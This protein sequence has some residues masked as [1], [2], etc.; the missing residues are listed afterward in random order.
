M[1]GQ[2]FKDN[3]ESIG[4]DI[5]AFSKKHRLSKAKIKQLEI[6]INDDIEPD[7]NIE[8]ELTG[9]LDSDIENY[10]NKETPPM[11]TEKVEDL[12]INYGDK[13]FRSKFLKE[14][15]FKDSATP[16]QMVNKTEKGKRILKDGK[17]EMVEIEAANSIELDYTLKKGDETKVGQI[18]SMFASDITRMGAKNTKVIFN[19]KFEK[20]CS[21]LCAERL[22][23]E[24]PKNFIHGTEIKYSEA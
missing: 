15:G 11:P 16:P 23:L 17:S 1:T 8:I 2:E 13:D 9:F 22:R 19:F 10:K 4:T 5:D 21:H 3:L 12:K 24:I 18:I 20:D 6:W 7:E 14:T